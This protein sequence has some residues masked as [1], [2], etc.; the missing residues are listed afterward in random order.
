VKRLIQK[1]AS[2]KSQKFQK[3]E[4]SDVG[5]SSVGLG[6]LRRLSEGIERRFVRA[7]SLNKNPEFVL[8][9]PTPAHYKAYYFDRIKAMFVLAQVGNIE[10]KYLRAL[11][12]EKTSAESAERALRRI[13]KVYRF[14]SGEDLYWKCEYGLTWLIKK[15]LVESAD[16]DRRYKKYE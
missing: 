8:D 16:I 2:E 14:S 13:A 1:A 9:F 15:N 12:L 3:I 6:S 5:P 4:S 11:N 10:G 7:V